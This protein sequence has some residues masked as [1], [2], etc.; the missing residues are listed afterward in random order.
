MKKIL[1]SVF[2][3]VLLSSASIVAAIPENAS[4]LKSAKDGWACKAGYVRHQNYCIIKPDYSKVTLDGWTCKDSWAY[5]V[6][7]VGTLCVPPKSY[8][9]QYSIA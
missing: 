6:K 9:M 1:L 2:G 4:Y 7:K 8:P 5:E 3:L